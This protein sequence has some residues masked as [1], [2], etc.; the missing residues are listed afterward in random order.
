[1][2]RAMA[3][4]DPNDPTTRDIKVPNYAASLTGDLKGLKI[5]VPQ[6]Y[7]F[8][9]I[10]P[11]VGSSVTTAIAMLKKLGGKIVDIEI[12]HF[13]NVLPTFFSIVMPEAATYHL[14][15]FRE[16]GHEYGAD[17]REL[18]ETGQLVLATTYIAAQ[19]NRAAI[20]ASLAAALDRVDVLVTPTLPVTAARVNRRSTSGRTA[21]SRFLLPAR[22]S[23][24]RSTFRGCR[25]SR[26]LAAFPRI[27]CL[28]ACNSRASHLMKRRS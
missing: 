25:R 15:T 19:R 24:A 26:F 20:A 18:L 23:F 1:M 7:F 21:R 13:D 14:K 9:D 16:R 10:Q 17:V 12:D 6:N 2:L 4:Y 8:D 27:R 3:G 11:A 5:G 28:S 22:V